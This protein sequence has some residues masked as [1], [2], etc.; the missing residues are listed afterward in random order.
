MSASSLQAYVRSEIHQSVAI[1]EFFHP[2]GNSLPSALLEDL[3]KEIHSAGVNEDAKLILLRSAGEKAFCA[4]ASFEEL[5]AIDSPEKGQAFFN[6]F[7][8]VINAIRKC[9]KLVIGRIQGKSVGG[10]VGLIAAVDYAIAAEGADIRLSELAIGFG[11]FVIAPAV[12][13]KIGKGAFSQLAI[14]ATHWRNADWAQKKGLYAE[15]HPDIASMDEAIGKL[16]TNLANS[17]PEAMAALKKICWEGTEHWD[18]LLAERAAISGRLALSPF[19]KNAI[20]GF[21]TK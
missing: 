11:P 8:Q 7:S 19:S 9:P 14:D 1:I 16:T 12:E 21:K 4:G 10:G 15:L 3:A 6:G 2:Q 17:H 20:A 13:R 18:Q 5:S